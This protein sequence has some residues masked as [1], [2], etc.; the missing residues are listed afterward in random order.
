MLRVWHWAL[1]LTLIVSL[2]TGFI[3]DLATMDVHLKSGYAAIGLALFRLG[4]ACWGGRNARFAAYRLTPSRLLAQLRA[5]LPAS[6]AHTPWGALL[7]LSLWCAVAL[8]TTA[9]LFASDEIA[10]EGPFAHRASAH[11]VHIATWVHTRVCWAI[12][13]LV[14]THVLAIGVYAIRRNPLVGAMWSGRKHAAPS[15]P[16]TLVLRGVLTLAGAAALVAAL[17]SV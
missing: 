9:G 5:R 8:Q 15:A 1:A 6:D 17:L 7:A 4:W 12:A 2:T 10:T 13:L 16:R 11:T 3:G 14:A